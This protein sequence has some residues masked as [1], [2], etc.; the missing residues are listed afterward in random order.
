MS[1][2]EHDGLQS[3]QRHLVKGFKCNQAQP[4]CD[5]MKF[6][7]YWHRIAFYRTTAGLLDAHPSP[8]ACLTPH[9]VVDQEGGGNMGATRTHTQKARWWRTQA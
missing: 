6:C 7:F 5:G 3:N 9:M 2:H 8:M 4:E 1:G